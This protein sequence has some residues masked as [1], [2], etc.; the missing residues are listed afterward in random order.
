MTML[1]SVLILN[2][3]IEVSFSQ[4]DSCF[5]AG[6]QCGTTKTLLPTSLYL[7]NPSHGTVNALFQ[8]QATVKIQVDGL[9]DSA[10][11]NLTRA[12]GSDVVALTSDFK[13]SE[14]L[15]S[16]LT[17]SV[18]LID[19]GVSY[20]VNCSTIFISSTEYVVSTFSSQTANSS[21]SFNTSAL[22]SS[23]LTSIK[24]ANVSVFTGF[25]VSFS[26]DLLNSVLIF[27]LMQLTI[28]FLL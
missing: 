7:E 4:P 19:Q 14:Y 5:L 16:S 27:G 11:I 2:L 26:Q 23:S 3:L 8:A 13:S 1:F 10:V 24:S 21:Q 17:K 18:A 25:G 22:H 28:T 9:D 15:S 12:A 6:G 20:S